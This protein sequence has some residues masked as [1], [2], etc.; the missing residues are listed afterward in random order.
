M[1]LKTFT[2]FV[3]TFVCAVCAGA[4]L[5][6]VAPYYTPGIGTQALTTNAGTD[7]TMAVLPSGSM[8]RT[9]MPRAGSVPQIAVYLGDT[10]NLLSITPFKATCT[11]SSANACT[12]FTLTPAPAI[13]GP[14]TPAAV[15]TFT[16][17]TPLAVA[18]WDVVGIIPTWSQPHSTNLTLLSSQLFPVAG[19]GTSGQPT[20]AETCYYQLN[21]GIPGALTLS[22]MTLIPNAGCPVIGV[23]MTPP[24]VVDIGDS[25]QITGA[26]S[27]G[28]SVADVSAEVYPIANS[29]GPAFA[30]LSNYPVTAPT[31]Q[32]MGWGG[33]TCTNVRS[34]FQTDALN[35]LAPGGSVIIGCG[36]N[37]VDACDINAG[38]TPAQIATIETAWLSMLSAAQTAGVRPIVMSIGPHNTPNGSTARMLN[39]DTI[40]A[41]LIAVAPGYGATVVDYRCTVGQF[42]SGGSVGNCW[43]YQPAYLYGDGLAIHPNQAGVQL[44]GNLLYAAFPYAASISKAKVGLSAASGWSGGLF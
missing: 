40:N 33:Q 37:D 12:V 23:Y 2:A 34:R 16:L 22:S 20:K 38:C 9:L 4:Q 3:F 27:P 21:T 42:R 31:Y 15:N 39:Q 5:V 17:A 19:G 28:D 24:Q 14:F 7:T 35:L 13:T 26:P 36:V 8:T 44:I 1:K 10:S 30:W 29:Y 41:W 18:K 25:I 11:S 43:D 32:G 6:P